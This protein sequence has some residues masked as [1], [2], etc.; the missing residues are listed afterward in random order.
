M[1]FLY[2][3]QIHNFIH[4]CVYSRK[5]ITPQ[6][7]PDNTIVAKFLINDYKDLF[8]HFDDTLSSSVYTDAPENV[9]LFATFILV[10]IDYYTCIA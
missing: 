8:L 5:T 6:E 1:H 3:P 7:T 9:K 2:F 10:F 4:F